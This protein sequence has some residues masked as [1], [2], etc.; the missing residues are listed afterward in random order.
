MEQLYQQV[1]L[2]HYKNPHGKGLAELDTNQLGGESHQVNPTCGD[3]VTMRV[4]FTGD[5]A[6]RTISSVTWDGQGC[7]I[8]QASISVLVQLVEGQ[9]VSDVEHVADVFRQLMDTRGK[10]FPADDEATESKE[11]L[12]DD[13]N[14]FTGVSKF[15]A[16]IKCALLGWSALRDTLAST[17]ASADAHAQGIKHC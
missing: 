11:D 17:G 8:S 12:L 6:Q 1:I 15:P 3:E 2:D 4:Q 13:A 14:A 7:S 10:G 5:G 16:R 9:S